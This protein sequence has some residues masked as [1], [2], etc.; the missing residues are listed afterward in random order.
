MYILVLKGRIWWKQSTAPWLFK[1]LQSV[2][3]IIKIIKV[4]VVVV[5]MVVMLVCVCV[6]VWSVCVCV[7]CVLCVCCVCVVCVLCV[8][9][10]VC[11]CMRRSERR[12]RG[13]S[14]RERIN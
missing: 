3:L 8:W 12:E 14:I 6:C 7:V 4:G 5:C 11:V 1:Y 13:G 9:E 2:A 10:Y